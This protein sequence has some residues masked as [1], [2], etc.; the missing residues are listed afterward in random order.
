MITGRDAAREKTA[1]PPKTRVSSPSELESI[2]GA[3]RAPQQPKVNV[4]PLA[5]GKPKQDQVIDTAARTGR[6]QAEA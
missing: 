5:V 4:D 2:P 1:T 3:R 6:T